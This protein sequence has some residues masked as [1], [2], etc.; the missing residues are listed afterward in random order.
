[1]KRFLLMLCGAM[2]GFVA[3]AQQLDYLT[4]KTT[5]GKEVSLPV[6]GLKI[7]FEGGVLHAQTAGQQV[8]FPLAEMDRMFF[9]STPAA[10][11]SLVDD[12]V[13]VAIVDGRLQVNAPAGVRVSVF[14]LDGRR[15]AGYGLPKGV[16]IVKVN[17]KTYKLLAK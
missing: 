11:G 7:T 3:R 2:L 16:Y 14:T 10:V 9:A 15:V 8:Q 4:C 6:D 13:R 5:D 1:M 17:D 12:A